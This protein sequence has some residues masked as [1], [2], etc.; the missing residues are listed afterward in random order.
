MDKLRVYAGESQ[1]ESDDIDSSPDN[2]SSSGEL[3]TAQ[4]D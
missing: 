3:P 1:E 4:L 2:S